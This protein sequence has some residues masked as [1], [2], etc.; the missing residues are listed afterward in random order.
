MKCREGINLRVFESSTEKSYWNA[1]KDSL[2]LVYQ[3]QND[4]KMSKKLENLR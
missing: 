1:S 3:G 2:N 4:C